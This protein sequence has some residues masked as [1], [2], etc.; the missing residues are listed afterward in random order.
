MTRRTTSALGFKR[1]NCGVRALGYVLLL[2]IT[3]GAM[4]DV[5]HSHG[6]TSLDCAGA[7]AISGAGGSYP[8]DP[9]HSHSTECPMCEFH[10]QLFSGLV[11]APLFAL[12]PSVQTAFV[13]APTVVYRSTSIIRPS[14]RAPPLA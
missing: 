9:G 13:S 2:L 4:V 5:V 10:Q 11:H 8:S 7:A 3:Y 14:G 6:T 1:A 12:T